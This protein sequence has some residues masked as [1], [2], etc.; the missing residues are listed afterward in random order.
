MGENMKF[1][2]VMAFVFAAPDPLAALDV[3]VE[4]PRPGRARPAA[5]ARGQEQCA[6]Q[7]Q[8]ERTTPEPS[9][10]FPHRLR[11]PGTSG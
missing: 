8:D 7:D 9:C 2:I 5:A 11:P 1:E 10:R 3:A 6:P 4:E